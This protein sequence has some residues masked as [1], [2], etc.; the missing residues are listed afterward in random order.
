MPSIKFWRRSILLILLLILH[1]VA[2]IKNVNSDEPECSITE[3]FQELFL[4]RGAD[5][6]E[7]VKKGG[8]QGLFPEGATGIVS[9]FLGDLKRQIFPKPLNEIRR[10]RVGKIKFTKGDS[11]YCLEFDL[12]LSDFKITLKMIKGKLV[13][14][15]EGLSKDKFLGVNIVAETTEGPIDVTPEVALQKINDLNMAV[16]KSGSFDPRRPQARPQNIS[17]PKGFI[18]QI[19]RG[20]RDKV[21]SKVRC[22]ETV[23]FEG[24]KIELP[25]HVDVITPGDGLVEKAK[26]DRLEVTLSFAISG[27]IKCCDCPKP[28][29][30]ALEQPQD[31][32]L[33]PVPPGEPAPAPAPTPAEGAYRCPTDAA[34]LRAFKSFSFF[35]SKIPDSIVINPN[36]ALTVSETQSGD[37]RVIPF[38]I[39]VSEGVLGSAF[40]FTNFD[41]SGK[42]AGSQSVRMESNE[43][44]KSFDFTLAGSNGQSAFHLTMTVTKGSGKGIIEG[45]VELLSSDSHGFSMH[46]P[47]LNGTI[48]AV[49]CMDPAIPGLPQ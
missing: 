21:P 49:Q 35:G 47:D 3:A 32:A 2:L 39:E 37:R 17:T 1:N 27:S 5:F 8:V 44:S 28:L 30:Q 26:I 45:S 34:T 23:N 36:Q 33:A 19:E 12:I 24:I 4:M 25:Y 46:N 11:N 31:E 40:F 42:P 15:F 9:G 6:D 48:I 13:E 38:R 41:A 10:K 14:E 22:G 16:I 43:I 18:A 29:D 7:I 20:L